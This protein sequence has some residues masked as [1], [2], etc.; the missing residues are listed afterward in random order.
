MPG[1]P[2]TCGACMPRIRTRPTT[3]R[4]S[5]KGGT[6]TW[7]M[8]CPTCCANR[9]CCRPPPRCLPIR[10]RS[11]GQPGRRWRRDSWITV[12]ISWPTCAPPW[13]ARC[14]MAAATRSTGSRSCGASGRSG[15]RPAMSARRWTRASPVS[16]PRPCWPRPTAASR[17]RCPIRRCARR[18]HRTW[19]RCRPAGSIG[20]VAGCNCCIACARTRARACRRSSSSSGCRATT[21]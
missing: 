9:C 20:N 19:R 15:A 8:T 6:R 17:R 5:G 4:R 1:W 18:W 2:P 3:W 14:S 12:P 21:T 10:C 16:P 11:C 13:R 7:P